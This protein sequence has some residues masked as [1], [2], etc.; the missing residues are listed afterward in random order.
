M[1]PSFYE[2]LNFPGLHVEIAPPENMSPDQAYTDCSEKYGSQTRLGLDG[3]HSGQERVPVIEDGG[4][5]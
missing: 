5:I 2:M 1:P 3:E 4:R